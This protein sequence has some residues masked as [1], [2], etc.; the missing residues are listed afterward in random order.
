MVSQAED[1]LTSSQLSRLKELLKQNDRVFSK[2]DLDIGEFKEVEHSIDTGSV[3]PIRQRLRRTPISFAEEEEKLLGKML[4]AKL[5]EP[6]VSEWDFVSI[7][8]S[9]STVGLRLDYL[10]PDSPSCLFLHQ[11]RRPLYFEVSLPALMSTAEPIRQ[12]L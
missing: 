12:R 2:N 4:D 7:T 11:N 1:N 9:T 8:L 10:Q 3:E 6:S 5:I